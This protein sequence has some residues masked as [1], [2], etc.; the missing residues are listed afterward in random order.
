MA[1]VSLNPATGERVRV[2]RPFTAAKI[3][4]TLANAH[5]ASEHWSDVAPALRARQL[6]KIARALRE[7]CDTLATLATVEMG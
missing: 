2:Y 5:S 1:L 7:E 6:L 4:R 3:S